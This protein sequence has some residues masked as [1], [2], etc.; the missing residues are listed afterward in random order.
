MRACSPAI[1]IPALPFT[2]QGIAIFFKFHVS[3]DK[4]NEFTRN[5][6]EQKLKS[7]C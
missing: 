3:E 6:I 4:S 7:Q 5:S 1:M 2:I